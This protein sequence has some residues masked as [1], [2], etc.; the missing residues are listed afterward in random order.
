MSL[1]E[2]NKNESVTDR[3][4]SKSRSQ[5]S[6]KTTKG[7]RAEPSKG[8][9]EGTAWSVANDMNNEPDD[10]LA[11]GKNQNNK[12][13]L[14]DDA[15]VSPTPAEIQKPSTGKTTTPRY[16]EISFECNR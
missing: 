10:V 7:P 4:T 12:T 1:M 2:A 8:N 11:E 3:P 16:V 15:R 6:L 14:A 9:A 13:D 5:E